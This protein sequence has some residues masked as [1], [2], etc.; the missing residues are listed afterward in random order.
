MLIHIDSSSKLSETARQRRRTRLK[1][2]NTASR[3][4]SITESVR[5]QAELDDS[6]AG[7]ADLLQNRLLA[8]EGNVSSPTTETPNI[9]G[10]G[11]INSD[12]DN[13]DQTQQLTHGM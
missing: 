11:A 4:S 3:E 1:R 10:E 7:V 9:R 8:E 6:T 5:P 12:G 13:H 2:Q